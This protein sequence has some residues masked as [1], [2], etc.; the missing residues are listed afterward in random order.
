[1][2]NNIHNNI[3]NN[4]YNN[5]LDELKCDFTKDIIDKI[6]N[7]N[8]KNSDVFFVTN[9]NNKIILQFDKD[10][11]YY[12]SSNFEILL[13][14][15]ELYIDLICNNTDYQLPLLYVFSN[16]VNNINNKLEKLLFNKNNETDSAFLCSIIND[17]NQLNLY[18]I[19]TNNIDLLLSNDTIDIKKEL[20]KNYIIIKY[21]L[22]NTYR[23][24]INY[25]FDLKID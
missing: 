5:I 14:I 8:K 7:K 6:K 19:H 15:Y 3:H 21:K 2:L 25:I 1:M 22:Q 11:I 12:I 16:I 17:L 9:F 4:I 24:I 20:D 23:K 18:N 13:Y 10:N